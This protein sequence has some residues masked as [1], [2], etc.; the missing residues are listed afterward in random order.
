MSRA[1]GVFDVIVI[2]AGLHGSSAALQLAKRKLKIL[3]LDRGSGGRNSSKASAGGLRQLMR[4]EPEI[5][6]AVEAIKMWRDI[7]ALVGDRCGTAFDGQIYVAENQTELAG[8]RKRHKRLIELGYQHEE[9]IDSHELKKLVP[10]ISAHCVGGLICRSDGFGSPFRSTHAFQKTA[11]S[12]GVKF[13]RQCGVTA[14]KRQDSNWAVITTNAQTFAAPIIVNSAGAWGDQI[15]AMIGDNVPI[16]AEAPMMMVSAP[17]NSFLKPVIIAANRKLS[18]KQV[19]NG[20][21]LIGGGHRGKLNRTTRET[22][23]DFDQLKLSAQ[24]VID[25]FPHM[26][27]VP[28]VRSWAGIEGLTPDRMPVIGAS[29]VA[30]GV[31]HSFGYSSHGYLLAP[32]TGRLLAEL[33]VDNKPSLPIA[34]F[35]VSRFQTLNRSPAL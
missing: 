17:V 4:L 34:P 9:L 18:F 22:W 8:L 23:V 28:V 25:F 12:L 16:S 32:V 5:P 30:R 27:N 33:I 13:M 10:V 21:V 7:E 20:T 15:A 6:L 3:L 26:A 2:G 14:I 24:T 29:S 11:E 19:P 35:H 31:F 1:N